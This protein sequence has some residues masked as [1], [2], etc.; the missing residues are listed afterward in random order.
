MF[1]KSNSSK[2]QLPECDFLVDYTSV[3]FK[4]ELEMQDWKHKLSRIMTHELPTDALKH[5]VTK[6]PKGLQL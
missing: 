5:F 3:I 4:A 6:K 2:K 1:Q